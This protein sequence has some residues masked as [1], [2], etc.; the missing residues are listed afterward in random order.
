MRQLREREPAGCVLHKTSEHYT[1]RWKGIPVW[2]NTLFREHFVI[3][4][5]PHVT[6]LRAGA[7]ILVVEV[8]DQI[9]RLIDDTWFVNKEGEHL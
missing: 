7:V 3:L 8:V 1:A 4:T 5:R 2:S 9:K 6:S